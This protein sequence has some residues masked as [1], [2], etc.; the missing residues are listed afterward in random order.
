MVSL[1]LTGQLGDKEGKVKGDIE[2]PNLSDENDVEE[3]DVSL[4]LCAHCETT[5]SSFLLSFPTRL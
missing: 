2:I 3:V 4:S 5:Y 1:S